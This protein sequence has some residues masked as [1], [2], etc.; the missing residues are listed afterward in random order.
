MLAC[1]GPGDQWFSNG[2]EPDGETL[3]ERRGKLGP[4]QPLLGHRVAE[5]DSAMGP[6][7]CLRHPESVLGGSYV[8]L[9]ARWEF[10]PKDAGRAYEEVV[11][12][13]AGDGGRV[14]FWSFREVLNERSVIFVLPKKLFAPIA[15]ASGARRAPGEPRP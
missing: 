9:T 4:F 1:A 8:R 10:G 15:K 2:R 6:V 5:A 14:C 12:I 3:E 11:F 7:R 13:G